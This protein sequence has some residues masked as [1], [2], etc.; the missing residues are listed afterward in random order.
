MIETQFYQTAMG[1]NYYERDV[2]ALVKELAR[3]N[4]L[5]QQLVEKPSALPSINGF[6]CR[7]PE[8]P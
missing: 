8:K 2:P 4:S 7:K 6:N 1:R 5:L 3:L